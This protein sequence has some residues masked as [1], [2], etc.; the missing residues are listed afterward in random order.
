[1]VYD[2]LTWNSMALINSNQYDLN[3]FVRWSTS[4]GKLTV[5]LCMYRSSGSTR[6]HR[7]YRCYWMDGLSRSTRSFWSPRTARWAWR[8]WKSGTHRNGIYL[9]K[10]IELQLSTSRTNRSEGTAGNY[11]KCWRPRWNW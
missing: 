2:N 3:N 4:V 6:R 7:S 5:V 1:M 8:T 10:L 9:A 11:R